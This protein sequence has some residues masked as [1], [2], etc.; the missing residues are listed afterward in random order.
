MNAT[1]LKYFM[2]HTDL[3]AEMCEVSLVFSEDIH[4]IFYDSLTLYR[5]RKGIAENDNIIS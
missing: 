2:N 4:L 3:H 5:T 1:A